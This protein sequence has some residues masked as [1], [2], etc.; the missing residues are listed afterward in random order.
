MLYALLMAHMHAIHPTSLIVLTAPNDIKLAEKVS[1]ILMSVL[2]MA[3]KESAEQCCAS[4][5]IIYLS[6]G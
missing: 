1:Y 5:R 2:N 3:P 6:S 4:V